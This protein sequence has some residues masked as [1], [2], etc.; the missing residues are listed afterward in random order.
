MEQNVGEA[1]IG[2]ILFSADVIAERVIQLGR[3]L[4]D[5]YSGRVPLLVVVLKGSA[6]FA[7]DLMRAFNGPLEVDFLAVSS[8]GS[9]T[10][11][12]GT[13]RIVKDLDNDVSGRDVLIVED[14]IDSG[15]TL[16]YLYGYFANRNPA[17]VKSCS[18][19][20][21]SP[22]TDNKETYAGRSVDYTGFTI[23]SDE[24]VIGYG[25]DLDQKYR[26]LPYVAT[27]KPGAA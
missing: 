3:Q 22:K 15:L 21:R 5:D 1:A 4:S 16:R 23:S 17:S 8:Y 27:C 19:L 7:A 2:R 14:I 6:V 11:S 25:L 10:T 20:V 24:F 18:L 13:V 12:S 26:N 9:S